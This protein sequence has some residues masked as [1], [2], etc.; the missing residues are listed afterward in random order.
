M[1]KKKKQKLPEPGASLKYVSNRLG[2]KSINTTADTYFDIT[3][4]IKEDELQK[5]VFYNQIR[6]AGH[7]K[8]DNYL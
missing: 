7:F 5:F 1:T 2:H 6:H 4:K 8:I 3:K